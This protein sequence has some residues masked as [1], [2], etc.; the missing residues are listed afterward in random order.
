M[1]LKGLCRLLIISKHCNWS[2]DH[3][4]DHTSI[5]LNRKTIEQV[6]NTTVLLMTF[7]FALLQM[8]SQKN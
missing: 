7:V 6:F 4:T 3:S 2:A 8:A 5:E 1:A